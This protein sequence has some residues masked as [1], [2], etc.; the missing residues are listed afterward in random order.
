MPAAR[1]LC[2]LL[3]SCLIGC[4]EGWTAPPVTPQPAIALGPGM[5]TLLPH[6]QEGTKFPLTVLVTV[7]HEPVKG[8]EVWW[9]DGRTPSNLSAHRSVSDSNGIATVIWNLPYIPAT[10]P[11]YTYD[12]QAS[13]PAGLGSPIYF[14]IEVFRCT[15]C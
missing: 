3:V 2:L 8:V 10:A 1:L 11:W 13:V 6:Q 9:D 15:K 12:A 14:T 4:D 7:N 5:T